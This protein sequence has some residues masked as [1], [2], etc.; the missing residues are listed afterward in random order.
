MFIVDRFGTFLHCRS[1]L[2]L[3]DAFWLHSIAHPLIHQTIEHIGPDYVL[4]KLLLL[5]QFQSLK[6]WPRIA[7]AFRG[8]ST[9]LR[10][11]DLRQVPYILRAGKVLQVLAVVDEIFGI[12]V[13]IQA[14]MLE[15]QWIGQRLNELRSSDQYLDRSSRSA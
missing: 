7:A 8:T 6:C 12:K 13:V 11:Q 14:Q 1:T 2:A 5:K 10:I 9:V 3:C 4:A 15:I